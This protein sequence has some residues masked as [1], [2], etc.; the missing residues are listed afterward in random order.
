MKMGTSSIMDLPVV[1][2]AV[3]HA[4]TKAAVSSKTNLLPPVTALALISGQRPSLTRAKGS[5][6]SFRLRKHQLLGCKVTLRHHRLTDFM[7]TLVYGVVPQRLDGPLPLVHGT[8]VS[9]GLSTV[10]TFPQIEHHYDIFEHVGGAAVTLVTSGS[11]PLV[12]SWYGLPCVPA[13]R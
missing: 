6:A 2:K 9:F 13:L 4:S 7:I 12:C 3:L 1:T 5:I 11:A 10:M 8:H